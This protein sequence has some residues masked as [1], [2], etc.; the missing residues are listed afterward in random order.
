MPTYQ[1]AIANVYNSV[2]DR[3]EKNVANVAYGDLTSGTGTISVFTGNNAVIGNGTAFTT[4]LGNNFVIRNSANVFVGRIASIANANSATLTTHANVAIADSAFKFHSY[5][6]N[7]IVYDPHLGTGNISVFTTN[8]AVIGTGTTFLTQLD[9]GYQIFDSNAANL[10][11][12]IKSVTSN[13]QAVF[14]TNSADDLSDIPFR[15]YNSETKNTSNIFPKNGHLLHNAMINWSRSGLIPGLTHVK[16]YHPPVQDPVTGVLV[17]FPAT[18]HTSTSN[19]KRARKLNPMD[20]LNNIGISN[21]EGRVKDFNSHNGIIGSSIKSA[22]DAIPVNSLIK[23][24]SN[25]AGITEE[26][27]SKMVPQMIQQIYGTVKIP[28]PPGIVVDSVPEGFVAMTNHN[29]LEESYKMYHGPGGNVV[30][31]LNS[32]VTAN[33][34]PT[35]S[36]HFALSIGLAPPSRVTDKLSDATSY[37]SVSTPREQLTEAQRADLAARATTQFTSGS[38]KR[39]TITGVPAAIPGMLN[40]VLQDENPENRE[41]YTPTYN[42]ATLKSYTPTS[43]NYDLPESPVN[44]PLKTKIIGSGPA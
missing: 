11:G 29:V 24:L 43:F 14:T 41:Y 8:N 30:Y 5:I 22:I 16:S 6:A 32:N 25:T 35:V 37:Y 39:L 4:Q 18:T 9:V 21:Y 3:I 36:D 34:Y 42:V 44:L 40:V 15:F 33:A 27:Y 19:K 20:S 13:S 31:V 28:A 2:T 23:K 17:N 10:F 38:D 12:V 26:S 7:V 1:I